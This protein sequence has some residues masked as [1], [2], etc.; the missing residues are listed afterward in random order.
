MITTFS[1]FW[2]SEKIAVFVEDEEYSFFETTEN[3]EIESK[4]KT[5]F[6]Y[7]ID[8][9]DLHSF[10]LSNSQNINSF[11]SFNVKEFSFEIQTPPPEIV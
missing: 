3:E 6:V 11:Y 1:L 5:L 4:L 10:S 2:I 8:L 9:F 7:Q